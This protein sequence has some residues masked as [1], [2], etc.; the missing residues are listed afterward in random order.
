MKLNKVLLST[1]L[2]TALTIT[3]C[4]NDDNSEQTPNY[5]VPATYI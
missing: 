1:L 2:M 3:S 4:S 5:T